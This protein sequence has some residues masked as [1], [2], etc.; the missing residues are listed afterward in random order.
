M[1]FATV[2][3]TLVS[4]TLILTLLYISLISTSELT[5]TISCSLKKMSDSEEERMKTMINIDSTSG[6]GPVLYVDVANTGHTT[7]RDFQKMDVIV[8]NTTNPSVYWIKYNGTGVGWNST[9]L[10][11]DDINPGLL[12]PD[13]TM[14][15]TINMGTY[16][17]PDWV[18]VTTPNGVSSSKYV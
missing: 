13:E 2:A 4:I 16:D 7:I 11:P 1:G 9:I 17:F 5:E 6:A 14:R 18:K 12:D 8:T 15:I 3:A 10:T